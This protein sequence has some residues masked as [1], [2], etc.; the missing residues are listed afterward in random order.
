MTEKLR[1]GRAVAARGNERVRLRIGHAPPH[2]F[3]QRRAAHARI[4]QPRQRRARKNRLSFRSVTRHFQNN[5]IRK[6]RQV[7]G[8]E[9][10]RI[11]SETVEAGELENHLLAHPGLAQTDD[12]VGPERLSVFVKQL[13]GLNA[14]RV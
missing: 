2:E 6:P 11:L 7:H 5:R 12:I 9:F 8:L 1:V 3:E 10:A 4:F 13:H 14:V